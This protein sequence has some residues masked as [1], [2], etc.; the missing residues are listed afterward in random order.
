[1]TEKLE[2]VE[3]HREEHGLNRCLELLRVSKGTW[4]RRMRQLEESKQEARDRRLKA[5]VLQVVHEHPAYG[6]R[7]IR[8]ELQASFGER[9]KA[10]GSELVF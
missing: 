3:R 8:P 9:V 10:K 6:Y 4:H 2:L 5:Q 7:R 1:M